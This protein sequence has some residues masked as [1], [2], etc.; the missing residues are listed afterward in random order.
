[1][2]KFFQNYTFILAFMVFMVFWNMVF[3]RKSTESL[4]WLILLG[5]VLT[6]STN[7]TGMFKKSDTTEQTK[8]ETKTPVI[9]GDPEYA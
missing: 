4:L 5:M 9:S 1:M 8:E 7:L 3:G 6:N 2:I